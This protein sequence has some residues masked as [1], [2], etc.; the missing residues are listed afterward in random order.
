M[1]PFVVYSFLGGGEMNLTNKPCLVLNSSYEPIQISSVRRALTLLVKGAVVVEETHGG[2]E[3]YPGIFMPSVVRLR[4]HANIPY[5]MTVLTRQNLYTRDR[6]C[7]QYCGVKQHPRELTLD[8]VIPESKGG[9]WSWENLVTACQKCNRRKADKTPEEAGMK[10]LHKP[11]QS[12][13]HTS[14]YMLRMIGMAEDQ[15]WH[16]YLYT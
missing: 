15:K 12:T 10:L 7:C 4:Y 16:R 3:I 13:V 8:H 6:L 1:P 2:K 14:R 9:K 11:R 5:R